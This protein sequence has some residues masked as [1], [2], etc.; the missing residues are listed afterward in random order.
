M[1]LLLFCLGG[2]VF[3]CICLFV[4]VFS[5]ARSCLTGLEEKETLTEIS[6]QDTTDI[7]KA[8]LT[9]SKFSQFLW[10]SELKRSVQC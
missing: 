10:I 7:K 9:N 5:T 1:L 6:I 3:W 4:F 8:H 2:A